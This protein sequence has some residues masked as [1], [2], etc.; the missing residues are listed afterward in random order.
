MSIY[1]ENKFKE[2]CDSQV[3]RAIKAATSN[4]SL[5]GEIL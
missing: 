5:I 2:E 4:A 3:I 1:D